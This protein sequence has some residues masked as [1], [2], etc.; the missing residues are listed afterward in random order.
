MASEDMLLDILKEAA[1]DALM[2]SSFFL[3]SIT[4]GDEVMGTG[5]AGIGRA[6]ASEY[7]VFDLTRL[8]SGGFLLVS[9][10]LSISEDKGME[11]ASEEGFCDEYS[12]DVFREFITLSISVDANK[13]LCSEENLLDLVYSCEFFR[14]GI[15]ISISVVARTGL[16]SEENILDL[17]YS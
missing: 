5:S 16:I 8:C 2:C 3:A 11:F 7:I 17:V 4:I 15:F 13:G 10:F 12:L 9:E 14:D 1:L 6:F